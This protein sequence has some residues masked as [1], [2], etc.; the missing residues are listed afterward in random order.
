MK[1]LVLL[2]GLLCC[3]IGAGMAQSSV[4]FIPQG[5]YTFADQLNFNSTF[6]R[7]DAGFNYGGS[8]QFNFNRHIGIEFLYNRM[9][10][11]AKLYNY[12]ALPGDMPIYQTSA[13]INYIMAGPVS[14]FPL[15]GSPVSLFF[16]ADLGAAIFTPSPNSFS[17]N[18]AFAYGFQ[19]GTNIYVDPRFGIRLSARLLG[20]APTSSGYY[21]GGWGDSGGFYGTNP[22]I[23]QFGFNVGIIIGLG[24]ALPAYQQPQRRYRTPPPP[25]KYYYY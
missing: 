20:T 23:V 25:R 12:G 6:G 4:E 24:K 8:F 18:A 9:Q 3:M 16:G 10:V 11:P 2:S 14:S 17:S 19:A 21:F 13:G 15:P 7:I 5:G 1:K 22:G